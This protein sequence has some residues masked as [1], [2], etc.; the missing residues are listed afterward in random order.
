[1][2]NLLFPQHLTHKRRLGEEDY[3]DRANRFLDDRM[4]NDQSQVVESLLLEHGF[5]KELMRMH[6]ILGR[7]RSLHKGFSSGLVTIEAQ[8]Q[9][10]RESI[11]RNMDLSCTWNF[12]EVCE[13]TQD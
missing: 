5:D 7:L 11:T 3:R 6:K 2:V 1:M 9:F 10:F 8:M 12:D 4:H 13:Q